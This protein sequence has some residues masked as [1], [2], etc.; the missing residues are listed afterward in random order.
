MNQFDIAKDAVAIIVNNSN[1]LSNI[2]VQQLFDIYTGEITKF[3]QL[4]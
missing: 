4:G 2:T 3:S 1:S